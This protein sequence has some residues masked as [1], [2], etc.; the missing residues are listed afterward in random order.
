MDLPKE[1]QT[2]IEHHAEMGAFSSPAHFMHLAVQLWE[3]VQASPDLRAAVLKSEVEEA[4]REHEADPASAVS[5]SELR[6]R[7]VSGVHSRA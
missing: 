7:L 4:I 1:L 2:R 6:Q 3:T 5:A